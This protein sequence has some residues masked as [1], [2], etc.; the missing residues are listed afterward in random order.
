MFF[1]RSSRSIFKNMSSLLPKI[2][3]QLEEHL[4]YLTI[5]LY[6]RSAKLFVPLSL[7][8]LFN[9]FV[10]SMVYSMWKNSIFSYFLQEAF[11]VKIYFPLYWFHKWL[12]VGNNRDGIKQRWDLKKNDKLMKPELVVIISILTWAENH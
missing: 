10:V 12:E 8:F 7:F 3:H 11:S 6:S 2:F 4:Y 1:S 9:F 5:L